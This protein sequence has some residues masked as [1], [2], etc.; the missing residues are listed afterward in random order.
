MRS[1]TRPLRILAL[2]LVGLLTLPSVVAGQESSPVASPEDAN[3]PAVWEELDGV[4]QVVMRT[5]G[6]VPDGTPP[7]GEVPVLRFVTGIVAQ[8]ENNEQ[9]ANAMDPI[10]DWVLASLQV[11]LVDVQLETESVDVDERG[12]SVSAL[13]AM[14]TTGDM[15][16]TISLV[17]VR[18]ANRVLVAGGSVMA[19]R[20]LM[21]TMESIVDIMV[22]R[23]P[24]GE[25]TRDNVGRFS[26]GLWDTF[27]EPDND[28]LDGMRRQ[29]DLP[30]YQGAETPS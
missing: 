8:F 19:D 13:T 16:L 18:E 21:P 17:L 6:D 29:G 4:Q 7:D 3:Q 27:P 26:G 2:I 9:A 24:G 22:E 30:I 28:V 11:N 5:W 1:G 15:P 23:E 10:S 25:E 12:D 20:D 14:G